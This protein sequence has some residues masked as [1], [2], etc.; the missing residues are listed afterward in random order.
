[1][2]TGRSRCKLVIHFFPVTDGNEPIRVNRI[3]PTLSAKA[4]MCIQYLDRR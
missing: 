3:K 4:W 2:V 1:M